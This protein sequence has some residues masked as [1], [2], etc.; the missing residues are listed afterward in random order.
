MTKLYVTDW[1][2]PSVGI[3]SET[4]EIDVPIYLPEIEG[5]G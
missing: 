5:N 1:G 2:D 3:F 4:W